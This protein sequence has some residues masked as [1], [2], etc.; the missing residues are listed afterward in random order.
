MVYRL[1][2]NSLGEGLGVNLRIADYSGVDKSLLEPLRQV[3]R[4]GSLAHRVPM[5]PLPILHVPGEAD[6]ETI[7]YLLDVDDDGFSG[8]SPLEALDAVIRQVQKCR[9]VITGSYH[10]GGYLFWLRWR[11]RP[12]LGAPKPVLARYIFWV[13]ALGLSPTW[14]I[15]QA[16]PDWRAVAWLLAGQTVI[17]SLCV[18]YWC[19]GRTWLGHFAFSICLILAAVPSWPTFLENG[20]TW[21]D[22]I[23]YALMTACFL[24]ALAAARVGFWL[25][26][27]AP[28][29]V[30][31]PQATKLA[32]TTA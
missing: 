14:L 18:I 23:G 13:R 29:Y 22:L 10:A 7:R 12:A 26:G 15:V 20:A 1:R 5:V 6:V 11:S 17:L 3:L 4:D 24:G 21:H 8:G 16:N 30:S 31:G 28:K 32:A 25:A 27:T 9:L 19:G 2:R